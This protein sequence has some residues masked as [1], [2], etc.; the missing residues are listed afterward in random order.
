MRRIEID[1]WLVPVGWVQDA[2]AAGREVRLERA[3]GQRVKGARMRDRMVIEGDEILREG[4]MLDERVHYYDDEREH[5]VRESRSEEASAPRPRAR[6]SALF[7]PGE[8]LEGLDPASL[9]AEIAETRTPARRRRRHASTAELRTAL[10]G[11]IGDR[12][13]ER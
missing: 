3:T 8:L 11:L 2:R 7:G 13:D 9:V 12:C 4:L 10:P 6:R 1:G 5:H